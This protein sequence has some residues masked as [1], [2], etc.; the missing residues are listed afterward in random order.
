MKIIVA[1]IVCVALVV[2]GAQ[3]QSITSQL[4]SIGQSPGGLLGSGLGS[5][6]G[7]GY[8]GGLGSGGLGSGGGFL[9]NIF[10][11][12]QSSNGNAGGPFAIFQNMITNLQQ[13]IQRLFEGFQQTMTN[14][15]K[16]LEGMFNRNGNL[17]NGANQT[18]QSATSQGV[19][20]E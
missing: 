9:S 2:V 11:P 13:F 8:G 5:G 14:G 4:P 20:Y 7:S 3:D 15:F 16:R 1:F 10:N 6:G 12:G 17:L 18:G 19:N